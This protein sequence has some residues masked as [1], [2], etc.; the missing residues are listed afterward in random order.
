MRRW[1]EDTHS[2]AVVA[3]AI[4][5]I[6]DLARSRIRCKDGETIKE[7]LEIEEIL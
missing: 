2:H 5:E 4:Q 6:E 3:D 1:S 7:A